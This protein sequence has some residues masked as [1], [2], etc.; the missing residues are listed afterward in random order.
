MVNLKNVEKYIRI[1]ITQACESE[2]Y[3]G[4]EPKFWFT[5]IGRDL[6]F[7]MEVLN[8]EENHDPIVVR[9]LYRLN[10]NLYKNYRFHFFAPKLTHYNPSE[11]SYLYELIPSHLDFNWK[12]CITNVKI[13]GKEYILCSVNDIIPAEILTDE[14]HEQL[15]SL[16]D[17]HNKY[18][19]KEVNDAYKKVFNKSIIQIWNYY[20]K[21]GGN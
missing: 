7:D 15:I 21:N 10:R 13:F 9:V 6:I 8:K 11:Y 18:Y 12:R 20:R 3:T 14:E 16:I 5:V 17:I 4:E 1:C 19:F 2:K